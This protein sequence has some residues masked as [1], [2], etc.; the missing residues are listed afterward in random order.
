M[1]RRRN[2]LFLSLG[3]ALSVV[4][5]MLVFQALQQA[6]GGSTSSAVAPT[7]TPV[8]SKPVP[9]AA[10]ALTAGSTIT[11]TDIVERQYPEALL[12]VG[13]VTDTAKLAGQSV[14]KWRY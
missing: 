12:P 10:R 1:R 2:V 8:P 7:P 4:T 6:G 14:A 9:V 5:G 3:L 13:V 11:T